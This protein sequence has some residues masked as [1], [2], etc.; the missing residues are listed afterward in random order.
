MPGDGVESSWPAYDARIHGETDLPQL[1]QVVDDENDANLRIQILHL[2]SIL[3]R[4]NKVS[5]RHK[6]RMNLQ[7]SK[8]YLGLLHLRFKLLSSSEGGQPVSMEEVCALF[9]QMIL[10]VH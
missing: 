1:I 3:L 2:I 5:S 6:S 4:T 9:D 10:F 8:G 7:D